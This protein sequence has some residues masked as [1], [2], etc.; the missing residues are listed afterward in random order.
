M[1]SKEQAGKLAKH[2]AEELPIIYVGQKPDDSVDA[3]QNRLTASHILKTIPLA[4]LLE[5]A[6]AAIKYEQTNSITARLECGLA[7]KALRATGKV[8]L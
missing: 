3:R 1:N 6:K 8:E 5:V 4:E 7:I 2:C